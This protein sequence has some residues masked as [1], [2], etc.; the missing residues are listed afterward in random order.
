MEEKT[1]QFL[2]KNILPLYGIEDVLEWREE[3]EII[4]EE[5]YVRFTTEQGDFVL[6]ISDFIQEDD[7]NSLK[8]ELKSERIEIDKFVSLVN[9][10]NE[11]VAKYGK[12]EQPFQYEKYVDDYYLVGKII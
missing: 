9:S 8:D 6:V 10:S 1:K 2:E 11:F 5:R 12:K 3:V 4:P 7:L